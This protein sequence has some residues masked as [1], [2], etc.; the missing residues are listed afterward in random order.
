MSEYQHYEFLA[1]ERA[2]DKS[3]M[4]ALRGLSSRAAITPTCFA[5]EYHWGD[6]KGSPEELMAEYYDAHVYV[7]TSTVFVKDINT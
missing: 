3:E 6:F 7:H 2:L 1:L 5:N 4:A